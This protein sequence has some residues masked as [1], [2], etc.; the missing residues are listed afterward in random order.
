MEMELELVLNQTSSKFFVKMTRIRGFI[1]PKNH[2]GGFIKNKKR[3]RNRTKI[4]FEIKNQTVL[5]SK[6]HGYLVNCKENCSVFLS[7]FLAMCHQRLT[8]LTGTEMA[9]RPKKFGAT[10]KRIKPPGR[11]A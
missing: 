9:G 1:N 3:V 6:S 2:T 8:S 11:S 5:V 4:P 10:T 7:F